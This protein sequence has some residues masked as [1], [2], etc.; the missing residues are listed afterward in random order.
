MKTMNSMERLS[1]M[2]T[3]Y[4]GLLG[5]C[6]KISWIQSKVHLFQIYVGLLKFNMSKVTKGFSLCIDWKHFWLIQADKQQILI[7]TEVWLD[8]KILSMSGLYSRGFHPLKSIQFT[9]VQLKILTKWLFFPLI[10]I[11]RTTRIQLLSTP[12][13]WFSS[14]AIKIK[15]LIEQCPCVYLVLYQPTR[16]HQ[17]IT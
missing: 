4:F 17:F 15:Q 3:N 1:K 5:I 11:H 10:G 9:G 12:L 13:Q 16:L 7:L 6:V 14:Q 2:I 8:L